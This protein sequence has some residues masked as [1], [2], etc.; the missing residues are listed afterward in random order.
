MFDWFKFD[1]KL[2]VKRKTN[3]KFGVSLHFEDVEICFSLGPGKL[4]CVP[5]RIPGGPRY[6][7]DTPGQL[8]ETHG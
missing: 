4:P 7:P 5:H 8:L 1:S 2:L 3:L 6:S